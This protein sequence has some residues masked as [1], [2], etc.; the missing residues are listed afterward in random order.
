MER[1]MHND[2]R[3]QA[4]NA[5]PQNAT[6]AI[7]RLIQVSQKLVDLS[8]R[9]TQALIH[10][11][12]LAFSII[13]DEKESITEQYTTASEQFRARLDDFRSVE[14]GLINR[15]EMLQK[16]LSEKTH[17]NNVMVARIKERA[18][19]STQKTLLMAQEYGQQKRSRFAGDMNPDNTQGATK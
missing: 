4:L 1:R 8:E 9:E 15:L 13:Q 5:L 17:G 14:K 6:A 2:R 16:N 11:D 19:T 7:H 12:M 10:R 3:K 18:E